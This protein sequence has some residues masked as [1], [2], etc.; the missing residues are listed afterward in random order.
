MPAAVSNQSDAV[1]L[2]A[3]GN[4][5]ARHHGKTLRQRGRHG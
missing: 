1:V 4:D 5:Q 2:R 3:D